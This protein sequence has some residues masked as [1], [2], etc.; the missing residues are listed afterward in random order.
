M[1]EE[2]CPGSI[3]RLSVSE[4]ADEYGVSRPTYYQ[5]KQNFDAAGIAGLVPAKPG[6]RGPH[7]IDEDVLA[8]LQARLVPGE[9][10]RARELAL[11]IRRDLAIDIHPRTIERASKKKLDCDRH[12]AIGRVI[13]GDHGAV[14]TVAGRGPRRGGAAQGPQRPP[15]LS[16]SGHVGMGQSAEQPCRPLPGTAVSGGHPHPIRPRRAPCRRSRPRGHCHGHP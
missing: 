13:H 16:A 9:P 11:L 5:A 3:D 15:A 6:P 7:K 10:V 2:P 1:P 12:P 8:F 14:R 4:V